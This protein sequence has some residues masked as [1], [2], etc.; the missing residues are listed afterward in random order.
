MQLR[1]QKPVLVEP[2]M[3]ALGTQY[4]P[5]AHVPRAGP[6]VHAV[7]IHGFAQKRTL[8]PPS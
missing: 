2:L 1:P 8:P 4:S 3:G 5:P 7:P 6:P